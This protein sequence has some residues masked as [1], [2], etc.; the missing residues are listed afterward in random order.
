MP[1]IIDRRLNP[2]DK[3][4]NNRKK[5]ID[6]AKAQV[7]K[8]VEDAVKNGKLGELENGRIKV[9]VKKSDEPSI[10]HDPNT[11]RKTGV[12]PGNKEYVPG[13]TLP[14]PKSG[15]GGAGSEGS[16]DGEGEDEFYFTLSKEEFLEFFFDD[17]ALP[18]LVK[19]ELLKMDTPVPKR[20]GFTNVGNPAQ[21][22][23][24]QTM[25]KALGRRI[26][27]NR[28]S[29]KEIA[30]LEN[31]LM[32]AIENENLEEAKTIQAEL[33]ALRK[34][35]KAVPFID[36]IDVRYKNY[37][38]KPSPSSQAVV[39]FIMDVSGSM[40]ETLKTMAKKFF[41]LNLLLLHRNYKNVDVVFI[42]H[43]TRA[44]ECSEQ[45]FFYKKESGGTIVSSALKLVNEI[46]EKRYPVNDWNIYVS[47]ASDGDNWGSDN[48]TVKAQLETLLPITQYYAYL[49]TRSAYSSAVSDLW[50]LYEMMAAA[51][52]NMQ[53]QLARSEGEIW[54]VFHELF[55]KEQ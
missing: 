33:N 36:P 9:P 27:L 32:E 5:F 8:A 1:T 29:K 37:E 41:I 54:D 50:P 52:G 10:H 15:S 4:I 17:L 18:D 7:K 14:K 11:G 35:A 43:H 40:D 39:F 23:T 51:H 22:D 6:R 30:E 49:E 2:R 13:D 25:K 21:L 45:D 47:Q 34:K 31:A 48:E 16:P 46:I 24:K 44:E 38:L 26:A 20:A 19:K 42:R 3:N 53:I 12:L 28:P 55:K